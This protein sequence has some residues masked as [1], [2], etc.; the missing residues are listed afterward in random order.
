MCG[1][2]P[3][4]LP[5]PPGQPGSHFSIIWS[6]LDAKKVKKEKISFVAFCEEVL[7]R[8]R[9]FVSC[10]SSRQALLGYKPNVELFLYFFPVL[11]ADVPGLC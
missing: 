10:S 7:G 1:A 8:R 6:V 2:H 5:S 3:L 11:K 9:C 4:P